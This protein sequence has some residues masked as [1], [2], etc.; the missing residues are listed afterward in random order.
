MPQDQSGRGSVIGEH[1]S[2]TVIL[3]RQGHVE[4]YETSKGP[5]ENRTVPDFLLTPDEAEDLY[6]ILPSVAQD[7]VQ[8]G[9]QERR[10]QRFYEATITALKDIQDRALQL[11]TDE[12]YAAAY[13]ILRGYVEAL[14][15]NFAETFNPEQLGEIRIILDQ[16]T[17]LTL[18]DTH[19]FE[20][21]KQHLDHLAQALRETAEQE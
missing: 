16:L 19:L 9:Y 18:E 14:I 6:L 2:Y 5:W 13:G 20:E 17:K 10:D 4:F 11:P 7:Q 21:T 3:H 8:P 12:R 1:G 15:T